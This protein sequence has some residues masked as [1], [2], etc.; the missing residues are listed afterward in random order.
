MPVYLMESI[1]SVALAV[2]QN[3]NATTRG[4][5]FHVAFTRSFYANVRT[6][7]N[8]HRP[9]KQNV[10]FSSQ[11]ISKFRRAGNSARAR[12]A[13]ALLCV[14]GE[15]ICGPHAAEIHSEPCAEPGAAG[16]VRVSRQRTW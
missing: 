11:F 12:A 6:G 16:T 7:K 8:P 3:A 13:A 15:S 5:R 1:S 2:H 4:V 9:T 10:M 14:G